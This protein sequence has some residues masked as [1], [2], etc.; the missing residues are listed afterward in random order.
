[1]ELDSKREDLT[2]KAIHVRLL[3]FVND[4]VQSGEFSER[5]LAGRLGVSQPQLHNVLKGARKLQIELADA[6]L[7]E[8]RISVL[9][10][11]TKEESALQGGATR[12]LLLPETGRL[13]LLRKHPVSLISNPPKR[14]AS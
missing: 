9:E 5:S 4:R 13:R 3:A 7:A 6:M 2:F 11:L 12:S 10:L 14:E 1:M 8:F